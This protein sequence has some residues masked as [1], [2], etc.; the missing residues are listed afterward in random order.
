ATQHD[1]KD[2]WYLEALGIG[3]DNQWDKFFAA[4]V[5]SVN[6]P[7]QTEAGRDVVWRARAE[8]ALPY[9]AA[10]A[11]DNKT[12]INS[13]LRYFRAFDFNSGPSKSAMLLKM[14]QDNSNNDV[15]L[16]KL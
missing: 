2:R 16:N 6:D 15:A 4:Y 5:V 3:A 12:P 10:L 1:G 14:I 9:I 7:L 11:S 13:R 8:K